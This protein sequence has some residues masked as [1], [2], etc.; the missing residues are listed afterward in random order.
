M[1]GFTTRM[2]GRSVASLPC[3]RCQVDGSPAPRLQPCSGV[4]HDERKIE[5]WA[6]LRTPQLRAHRLHGNFHL[7]RPGPR[8]LRHPVDQPGQPIQ[9][10]SAARSATPRARGCRPRIY[11]RRPPGGLGSSA[12]PQSVTGS[13]SPTD[14][15]PGFRPGM[16]APLHPPLLPGPSTAPEAPPEGGKGYVVQHYAPGGGDEMVCIL[17]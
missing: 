13:P 10:Q 9:H 3:D 11:P 17:R 2:P 5:R 8:P 6:I 4:G 15:R 14:I 16:V 7:D 12:S 1:A